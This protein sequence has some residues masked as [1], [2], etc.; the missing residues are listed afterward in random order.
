[1]IEAQSSTPT[2][3]K[4][5]FHR[6]ITPT[7]APNTANPTAKYST[8][9][10]YKIILKPSPNNLTVQRSQKG[11]RLR[12]VSSQWKVAVGYSENYSIHVVPLTGH[13]L[14]HRLN[15]I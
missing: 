10:S 8:Q 2:M 4:S 13:S 12:E 5:T 14:V 7:V 15:R 9:T 11:F 1:M 3:G 6:K